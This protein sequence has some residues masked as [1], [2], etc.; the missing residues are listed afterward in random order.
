MF[1]LVF[2]VTAGQALSNR[3]G[4]GA[5]GTFL[6]RLTATA[7]ALLTG[8]V[9]ARALRVRGYGTYVLALAWARVFAVPATMGQ[10][11]LLIR[12]VAVYQA[13]G[14]W[15]R[16]RGIL[17]W[18]QTTSAV[19]A[20]L[21][22]GAAAV[23]VAT[24]GIV[25]PGQVPAVC[26][27]LLLVPLIALIRLRQAAMQGMHHVI[28]SNVPES[29]F[30]PLLFLLS[31]AILLI[32]ARAPVSPVQAIALLV[33][34]SF[35]SLALGS[36]LLR[37]RLPAAA[38]TA[39]PEY[40]KVAWWRSALP[41]M[42]LAVISA[43]AAELDVIML[44]SIRGPTA[45]GVFRVAD[46]GAQLVVFVSGVLNTAIAPTFARLYAERR[47]DDL[48][49]LVTRSAR[50]T[51][52]VALPLGLAFIVAGT[53]F[54]EMFGPEFVSGKGA[55]AILAM[56]S[57]VS[58]LAGTVNGLLIMTGHERAVAMTIALAT[59][60]NAALNVMLIPRWGAFG[61][62]CATLASVIVTKAVLVV[63]AWRKLGIATTGLAP[64]GRR[65]VPE[66]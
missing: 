15:S 58:A 38:L 56:A 53:V 27:G 12:E 41:L 16:L 46:R 64:L 65:I 45:A 11:R 62:A 36:W 37:R 2:G 28:I 54:L 18:S 50:A 51:L 59:A 30:R 21:V 55:L 31:F 66:P 48:Q 60:I 32:V 24:T 43:V 9:L 8:L 52:A 63:L 33:S 29:V 44:G 19:A 10:D 47:M 14:S 7:L 5:A 20:V 26:L 6:I 35:V 17:Q 25:R 22:A 23:L 13:R 1:V 34:S 57:L 49:R 40:D 42:S 4:R 3:L 39:P 61:A